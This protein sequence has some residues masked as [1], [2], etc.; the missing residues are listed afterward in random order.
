MTDWNQIAER[1]AEASGEPFE[2]LPPRTIGGGCVNAAVRLSD[3]RRSYFVK[4]NAASRLEMFEAEEAGLQALADSGA[5]RVPRPVASGIAGSRA[6]LAMEYIESSGGK[7]GAAAAAGRQLATLHRCLGPGFGW[8]RDNTVGSTHQPNGERDDW[9][10]F[11][12]EQRLGFQLELGARNG[13]GGAL[14]RQGERLLVRLPALLEHTPAPSLLHGDLWSGNLSYDAEGDPVIFDPAVYY[15]DREADL[16]MTELFG[17]FGADFY[18]AYR[19]AW[20]LDPAYR[21]RKILYNLYHILN[22]MNMFGGGY[23]GQARGMIDRLL[24]EAG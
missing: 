13:Y 15:G 21:V 18:S 2:P 7:R 12:R 23:Q 10:T 1:I 5:I 11:W 19:E 8:Y 3:G 14:Q 9:Q 20:P 22:H 24:A 17:G 6:W 4:T 16:A